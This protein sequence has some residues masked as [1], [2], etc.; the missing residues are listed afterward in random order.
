LLFYYDDEEEGKEEKK[1]EVW[2]SDSKFFGSCQK[3]KLFDDKQDRLK[4]LARLEENKV[5]YWFDKKSC[6]AKS[7][8]TKCKGTNS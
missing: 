1:E 2:T 5:P 3:T 4:Q 6:E 7:G 8:S